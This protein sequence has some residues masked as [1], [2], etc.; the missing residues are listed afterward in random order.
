MKRY[1]KFITAASI[2]TAQNIFAQ[3]TTDAGMD[4]SAYAEYMGTGFL[5][6]LF[7]MFGIFLFKANKKSECTEENLIQTSA[8][9]IKQ[10]INAAL[11]NP[12][13]I[14]PNITLDLRRVGF[15]LT[16]VLI[17]FSTVLLLLIIQK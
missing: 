10:K 16:S 1:I 12:L 4:M 2:F 6:F 7:V 15:V 11:V 9:L 14:F 13:S 3:S 5:V 8:V 17:M